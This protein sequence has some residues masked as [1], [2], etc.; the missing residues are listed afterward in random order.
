MNKVYTFIIG[1]ADDFE[2][3]DDL[4]D[5]VEAQP[6]EDSS[7]ANY[8]IFEFDAP[9]DCDE[10]TVTMIGRGLAFSNDWCLDHTFSFMIRGALDG[11]AEKAAF[12]AGAQARLD[13]AQCSEV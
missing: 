3:I 2:T 11:P 6:T 13:L 12:D 10:E 5:Y 9:E 1:S 4:Q 8:S 7:P